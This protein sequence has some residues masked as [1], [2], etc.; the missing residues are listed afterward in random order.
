M[1]VE[2][3]LELS[4]PGLLASLEDEEP[5]VEIKLEEDLDI[6]CHLEEPISITANITE[7]YELEG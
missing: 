3:Y 4:L 6:E 2:A 7:K 1:I 5:A